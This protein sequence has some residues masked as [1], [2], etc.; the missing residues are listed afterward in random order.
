MMSSLGLEANLIVHERKLE[1][2][3]SCTSLL[4]IKDLL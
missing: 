3:K 2:E 4:A 1:D